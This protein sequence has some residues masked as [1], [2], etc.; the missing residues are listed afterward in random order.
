MPL[1]RPDTQLQLWS[2]GN[3]MSVAFD[4]TSTTTGTITWT[5]P[6]TFVAYDGVIVVMSTAE[7]EL[8]VDYPVDGVKYQGFADLSVFMLTSAPDM[9]GNNYIVGAFYHD[10]ITASLNVVGLDPDEVYFVSVY[11]V[12]NTLMYFT[13]GVQSYTRTTVTSPYTGRIPEST[14]PPTTPTVGQVYY[15]KTTGKVQMW[16]GVLWVDASPTVTGYGTT[17]PVTGMVQGDYFYIEQ[18]GSL[19]AYSGSSWVLANTENVGVPSWLTPGIGGD[20]STDETEFLTTLL[21]RKL[22]WPVVCVELKQEHFDIA[23]GNALSHIR[24]YSEAAYSAKY[25]L[26]RL[27]TDQRKYYLNSPEVGSN[28]IV[29]IIKINRLSGLGISQLGNN[30]LYAQ[31]FLQSIYQYG[32]FDLVTL[33]NLTEFSKAF[34]RIF[35]GDL[36]FHW[37]EATRE[38]YILNQLKYDEFVVMECAAEKTDAELIFGRYTQ[39]WIEDWAFAE[40]CMAL[41]LMRSKFATLPGPGGIVMNGAELIAMAQTDMADLVRQ[42]KDGE[43]GDTSQWGNTS[44]TFG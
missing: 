9:L 21:K 13:D 11:P 44:F 15:N 36:S 8:G 37:N 24:R 41:G 4:R 16:T 17:L 3:Q 19:Y 1:L 32:T 7:Q 42:C 18:T 10:K 38:L 2:E 28:K 31:A 27:T 34:D 5:L 23:I 29:E 39:D 22:G 12:S 6:T 33:Y 30:G 35:A 20:G 26:Q 14:A 43:L 40:C 25:Y